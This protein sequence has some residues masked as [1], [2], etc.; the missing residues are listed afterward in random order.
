MHFSSYFILKKNH[1]AVETGYI[2]KQ[3]ALEDWRSAWEPIGHEKLHIYSLSTPRS[4]N[5]IYFLLYGQQ[6]QRYGPIFKIAIFGCETSPL[7]KSRSCTYTFFLPQRVEVEL[8]FA[9]RAAVS[10]IRAH[11]QNCYIWV[12]NFAIGQISRSC[13]YTFFLPKAVLSIRSIPQ[14]YF[15]FMGSGFRDTGQ[16]SK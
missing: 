15:C 13:A 14:A 4:P 1:N 12:W 3:E 11:F 16:F 9:L 8:I 10:K 5:W 6:C 2:R 7:A